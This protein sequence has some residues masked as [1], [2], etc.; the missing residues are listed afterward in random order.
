MLF[1]TFEV[2]TSLGP[3]EK[4]KKSKLLAASPWFDGPI[5][6]G[7]TLGVNGLCSQMTILRVSDDGCMPA[8]APDMYLQGQAPLITFAHIAY[9]SGMA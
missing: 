9:F 8:N 2:R 1:L 5:R 6:P 4:W 7:R 3:R